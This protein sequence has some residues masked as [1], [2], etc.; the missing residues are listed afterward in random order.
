MMGIDLGIRQ[1]WLDAVDGAKRDR[2]ELVILS[3]AGSYV[4]TDAML[5]GVDQGLA[6]IIEV[7]KRTVGDKLI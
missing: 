3:D 5:I 7:S 6:M 1:D 2:T 4:A